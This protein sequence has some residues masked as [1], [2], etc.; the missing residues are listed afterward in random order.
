VDGEI[1]R[2]GDGDHLLIADLSRNQ[3]GCVEIELIPGTPI[4]RGEDYDHVGRG[5]LQRRIRRP[6]P[7]WQYQSG[8]QIRRA[9]AHDP[10]K[11]FSSTSTAHIDY[12]WRQVTETAD[13]HINRFAQMLG[14]GGRL[15]L[16]LMGSLADQD[17][18]AYLPPISDLFKWEAANGEHY[19]HTTPSA[20]I[21]LYD[22]DANMRFAA[23]TPWAGYRSG[24]GRGAYAMLVDSRLPFQFVNGERVV[25]GKT[26]L[27]DFDIIVAPH[28]LCMSD[29]EAAAL[30]AF[31]STGGLLI[32]SGMTAGFDG[33]GQARAAMPLASFPISAY[34]QPTSAQ[35]WVLDSA[36]GAL[37]HSTNPTPVDAYYFGGK[38][39]AG[40]EN[41]LPFMPDIRWGP[42]EYSYI[43]PGSERRAMPGLLARPYGKGH[44][45]HIPFLNEWQYYRDGLPVNQ[46]LLAALAARY[47][48]P[49]PFVLAGK[50]AVELTVL[51][52]GERNILMHVINYTGQRNG[53]YDAPPELHGLSIGVLNPAAGEV[54]ALVAGRPLRGSRRDGDAERLWFDLPPVGAF[55]A[56]LIST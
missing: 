24:S 18:Q 50:G 47:A 15:D 37:K 51:R 32:A 39:R 21:G 38:L 49:Q 31:V 35:G 46:S 5:E 44:A 41:L 45:V 2:S 16:Y 19:A 48:P 3:V 30:D 25:D 4:F 13:Y 22:S 28:V 9:K 33:K 43:V 56:V 42:P 6:A 14:N 1:A 11:P 8:E 27:S 34:E 7:E 36:N 10:G 53:R 17:D 26:K 12:P 23:A 40:A 55:E 54:H 29:E 52:S 20:R